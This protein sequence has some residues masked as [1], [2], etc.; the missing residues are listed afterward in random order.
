M[1]KILLLLTTTFLVAD[2][3]TYDEVFNGKKP[4]K[5]K[6]IYVQQ[7]GPQLP[8]NSQS[9]LLYEGNIEKKKKV[10]N[11]YQKNAVTQ[12]DQ[13]KKNI[14][15]KP[16]YPSLGR[17]SKVGGVDAVHSQISQL[18][19]GLDS[20]EGLNEQVN[21]INPIGLGDK[22]DKTRVDAVDRLHKMAECEEK[23]ETK[24][25]KEKCWLAKKDSD[26]EVEITTVGPDLSQKEMEEITN[27]YRHL[28][29]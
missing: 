1:K 6:I 21:M 5:V 9:P 11:R 23:A 7:T 3:P 18:E 8:S 4:E 22:I 17:G 15:N 29:Q 24:R 14:Q 10:I 19:G 25:E 12:I 13:N 2:F 16:K 26:K 27:R 20:K 28:A